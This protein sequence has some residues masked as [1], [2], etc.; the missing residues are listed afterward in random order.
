MASEVAQLATFRYGSADGPH[1]RDKGRVIEV[2]QRLRKAG[3]SLVV[4]EHDP[5][6]M[7]A[8]DRILDI[9]PG[10]GERGGQIVFYGRPQ[11]LASAAESL[12]AAYL[13]GRKQVQAPGLVTEAV[14]ATSDALVVRGAGAHNLRGIDVHIPLRRLVCITGVSGSG[15]STLVQDVLHPALLKHFGKPTVTPGAHAGLEGVEHLSEVV[16]VDQA[17]IGRTTRSNPASYVGAFDCIRKLFA[18]QPLAR[19]RKY[20]LGTFSFNSGNGRCPTCS[21]NGFEHVEM[22]FLS[23]VY[24]RCPDC[25]GRRYRAEILEVKRE[26]TNGKRAHIA[27]VLNMTVTE[28]IAFF[29][30][31][32]E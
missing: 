21:G 18:A 26:G 30:D 11:Q 22:Q 20:T 2:M 24:L 15:K 25:D 29:A 14:T 9:G 10:P 23:D 28:A 16:L 1:R 5:Q 17:P 19:E 32:K 7:Q 27:D 31:S 12:T 13:T 6:V 3:N 4:V 8:A